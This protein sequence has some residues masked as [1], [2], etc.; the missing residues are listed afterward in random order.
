MTIFIRNKKNRS[1][2]EIEVYSNKDGTC[3]DISSG[4]V[5][6][7]YSELLLNEENKDAQQYIVSRFSD[8]DE[9]RA[10]YWEVFNG[11]GENPTTKQTTDAIMEIIK[12]ICLKLDLGIVT[13]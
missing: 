5:I 9:L 10:W 12:P 6:D 3:K 4:V 2:V 8:I 1:L 11:D 13:D 7:T